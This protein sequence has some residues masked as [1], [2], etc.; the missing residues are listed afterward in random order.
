M[1]CGVYYGQ[2]GRI[3]AREV[4]DQMNACSCLKLILARFTCWQAQE[5]SRI[6][7]APDFPSDP[8]LTARIS[9]IE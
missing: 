9:L 8:G 4:Y 7:A 2:R 5:T 6:A 3:S 1:A